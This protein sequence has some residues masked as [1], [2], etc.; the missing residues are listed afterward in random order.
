MS[1]G[2]FEAVNTFG[3]PCANSIMARNQSVPFMRPKI[4]MQSTCR[5]TRFILPAKLNIIVEDRT[6][7]SCAYLTR[8][9]QIRRHEVNEGKVYEIKGLF[10]SFVSSC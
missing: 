9:V 10:V 7:E 2:P 4:R 1:S 6:Q 3:T 5:S 8:G